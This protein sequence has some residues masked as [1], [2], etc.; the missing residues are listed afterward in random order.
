VCPPATGAQRCVRIIVCATASA[1]RRGHA[2]SHRAW[3]QTWTL[4]LLSTARRR[5]LAARPSVSSCGAG[6]PSTTRAPLQVFRG[7]PKLRGAEIDSCIEYRTLPTVLYSTRPSA[8]K[9][10]LPTLRDASRPC[11]QVALKSA[12]WPIWRRG[13]QGQRTQSLCRSCRGLS[14][15]AEPVSCMRR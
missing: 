7:G 5:A 11:I 6:A 4:C 10:P 14:R 12:T 2:A 8:G 3:G 1:A 9:P 13:A 15:Y